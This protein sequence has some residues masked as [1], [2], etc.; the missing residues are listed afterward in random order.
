MDKEINNTF[1]LNAAGNLNV[2]EIVFYNDSLFAATDSGLYKAAIVDN[3]SDFRSWSAHGN[4]AKI[5]DVA[6]DNSIL[7]FTTIDSLYVYGNKNSIS[8]INSRSFLESTKNCLF[9]LTPNKGYLVNKSGITEKHSNQLIRWGN[10]IY[11]S[12]DTTWF[13][14]NVN[15]LV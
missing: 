2:N 1:L 10:D 15:G 11:N 4:S 7:Y 14:D 9:L 8:P 5:K 13:A 12:G 3:L 6:T